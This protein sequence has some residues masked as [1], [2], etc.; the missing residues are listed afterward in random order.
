[1]VVAAVRDAI[2]RARG[3]TLVFDLAAIE[4]TMTA[5][6]AA[7]RAHG[8]RVVLAAKAFPLPEVIERAARWLDGVDLAGAGE[9]AMARAVGIDAGAGAGAGALVS[10]TDPALDAAAIAALPDGPITVT[11]ETVAQVRAVRAARP[12]A[13]IAARLSISAAMPGDAAVGALQAGDGHRRSRFGAEDDVAL[14]ALVDAAR[15][16]RTG[17]HVH[18]AGVV[19]TSPARWR[20]IAA[21]VVAAAGRAGL[22]PAFV[23]LGGGWH[24]VAGELDAALAAVRAAVPRGIELVIEPGRLFSRGAGYAVGD[25]VAA[26]RLADRELRVVSLSRIAHLRWSPIDLIARAPRPGHGT[27]LTVTG[28]TCFED[29]VLGDWTVDA[30]AV[31]EV[32]ARLVWSG[33]TGYSAAWNRGFAGVPEAA[34]VVV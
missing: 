6:A 33:V 8:V 29:D 28:P 10:I 23:D 30:A 2:E 32:G 11:C 31:P 15:G 3:P 25:V 17:V 5:V 12:A 9:R 7:A 18:S 21:A 19:P 34:I 13:A 22:E 4:A 20:A 14:R 26:R 1:M 16:A 27:K 24:G